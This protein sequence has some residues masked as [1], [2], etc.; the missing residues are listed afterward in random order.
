M[1]RLQNNGKKNKLQQLKTSYLNL[2]SLSKYHSHQLRK[3]FLIFNY[4]YSKE[5][6][7]SLS[8]K[9]K[10]SCILLL[11]KLFTFNA[12]QKQFCKM[13]YESTFMVGNP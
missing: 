4:Y 2:C 3:L 6:S 9:S 12:K 7:A 5:L 8:N 10:C 11:F 1:K 13:F